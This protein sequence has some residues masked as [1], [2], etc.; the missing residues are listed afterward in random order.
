M[1]RFSI[2]LILACIFLGGCS[3]GG[4]RVPGLAPPS[5]AAST[6]SAELVEQSGLINAVAQLNTELAAIKA[7]RDSFAGLTYQSTLPAGLAILLAWQSYL[8]HKREMSRL[9][10]GGLR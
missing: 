3:F 5:S 2:I 4:R 6:T 7:G 10:K 8:S 9:T 1:T